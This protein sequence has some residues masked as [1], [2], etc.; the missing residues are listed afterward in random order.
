MVLFYKYI[1]F[2]THCIT[3][4]NY[5]GFAGR[6]HIEGSVIRLIL[7]NKTSTFLFKLESFA[8]EVIDRTLD[9]NVRDL[10]ISAKTR[11]Q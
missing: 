8:E 4:K 5:L 1:F 6:Y 11:R 2:W 10:A 3:L 7:N 9:G